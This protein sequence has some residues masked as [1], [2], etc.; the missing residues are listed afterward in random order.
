[1]A[2][3]S[4]S[5][6]AR[7]GSA[8]GVQPPPFCVLSVFAWMHGT[9]VAFLPN[10]GDPGTTGPRIPELRQGQEAPPQI[11]PIPTGTRCPSRRSYIVGVSAAMAL[12]GYAHSFRLLVLATVTARPVACMSVLPSSF[13]HRESCFVTRS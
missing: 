6:R 12:S 11:A 10:P 2:E 8:D 4:S 9:R 3:R 13:Q 7:T 5:T 1:M